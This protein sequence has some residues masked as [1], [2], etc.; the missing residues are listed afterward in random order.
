VVVAAIA[1]LAG[2]LRLYQLGTESLWRDEWFSL[3]DAAHL[4]QHNL[5]R[6]LFYLVLRVWLSLGDGD[7]WVRLPA[8]FF[9]VAAIVLLYFFGRR[10]VGVPAAVVACLVMAIAVP[11][12]DHSQEV[13]M[14]TM[15]SALTLASMYAL[16]EWM[17]SGR[18]WVLGMHV[19]LT[20]FAFLTTSTVIPGL[21]LAGGMTGG[22]LLYRRSWAAAAAMLIGYGLLL[23]TWWPLKRYAAMAIKEGY[24][25][26]IERPP[27]W[28]LLS[29]HGRLLIEAGGDNP[30]HIIPT[31]HVLQ[32]ATSLLVLGMVA[33]ALV[34]AWRQQPAARRA[35]VIAAW[36]YAIAVGTY[37]ISI[38]ERPVWVLRYF[39]YTAPALY[40]LLG[41]G[42]VSLWRW[43]RP[44]GCSAA[45]A[46]FGLTALALARYYRL[47]VHENWRAAAAVMKDA[48]AEDRIGIVFLAEPFGHYY[49]GVAPL[50]VISPLISERSNDT[51]EV[52]K[53]LL[54]QIP[55][56]TGRTWIVMREDP[57]YEIVASPKKLAKYLRTR[58]RPPRIRVFPSM[59]GQIDVI[60]FVP[61]SGRPNDHAPAPRQ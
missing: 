53:N 39:H 43:L 54:A 8:A 2:S 16:L 9:G 45:V 50:C 30:A 57:R 59:Q 11:E 35:P 3:R 32:F 5:H 38:L 24:L 47:P 20:Y 48:A 51:E 33:V 17:E 25:G 15:A 18:V 19:L 1:L 61:V 26:W 13:R 36:F 4:A 55:P 22:L 23:A 29:L 10:M 31:P 42:I 49:Q 40:L 46:L 12:L 14:Y 44:A 6:P 34:A 58:G 7:V 21:L 56:H 37:A 28:A 27:K 52:V 41:I 60:D